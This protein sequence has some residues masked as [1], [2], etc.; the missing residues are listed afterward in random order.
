MISAYAQT[1]KMLNNPTVI[2]KPI[3]HFETVFK[4]IHEAL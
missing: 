1:L 4:P 2:M 3:P